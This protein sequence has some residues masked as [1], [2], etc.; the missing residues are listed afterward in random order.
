MKH[1]ARIAILQGQS[2]LCWMIEISKLSKV[3]ILQGQSSLCW[4]IEISKLSKVD[5]CLTKYPST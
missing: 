4:M 3:A 1:S 2:S 5:E